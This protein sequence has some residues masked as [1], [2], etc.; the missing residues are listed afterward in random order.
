MTT[1]ELQEVIDERLQYCQ[2]V[3][4]NRKRAYSPGEDR[5]LQLKL[6]AGLTGLT[7]EQ[8][9]A[10]LMSKQMVA[11]YLALFQDA[12]VSMDEILTDLHNYLF[13][14]EG[15][16]AESPPEIPREVEEKPRKKVGGK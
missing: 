1:K 8:V 15:A 16:L 10:T 9:A 13:L 5:L 7:P 4:A 12:T 3:M 6:S 11:L 14:I 2:A